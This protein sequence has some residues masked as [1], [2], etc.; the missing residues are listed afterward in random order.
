[1]KAVA[2]TRYLPIDHPESLIDVELPKPAAPKGHDILVK[3]EAIAVNPVDYKIRAPKDKVEP[4]PKVLGWDAAGV[5]EAVGES[6]SLFRPGDKVY[7]AGDLTR[8]GS[9]AEFQL[10]DERI[11]GRMP[12]TLDF[13]Q[14]AALPLTSITAWE[15]L[16][17]RL[18][19]DRAGAHRGKTL[20]IIG[21]AGGVGSIAIQLAKQAGL[22]VIATAGRPESRQWV[23][24]LGADH[25]VA[26]GDALV[27]ATRE[28][29]FKHVD[30][31]FC[32]SDTESYFDAMV[33]LVAPQ[34][35]IVTIVET[36]RN[37]PLHGLKLKSAFFAWELMFTRSMFLT[38]DMIEQHKL[39]NEVATLVDNGTLRTTLGDVLGPVNAANLKRAHALLEDGK[40]IGKLVLRGFGD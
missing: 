12:T 38:D 26:H 10:V 35:G 11:V 22:T 30:Y 17:D 28:A 2:L 39:L 33:E 37:L 31:I 24:E 40:V 34:G 25:T 13:A 15:A 16:F 19:I 8:A 7:Y 4:S 3:V 32:A 18:K 1:M 21:G 5:V 27:S 6:V 36:E 23:K 29:G 9:N 14:A 20:L